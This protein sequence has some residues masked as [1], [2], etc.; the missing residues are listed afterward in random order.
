MTKK[1]AREKKGQNDFNI[2]FFICHVESFIKIL[3]FRT[4][5]TNK[6]K[7]KIEVGDERSCKMS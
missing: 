4:H 1:F 5:D 3:S 6:A 7:K 2:M